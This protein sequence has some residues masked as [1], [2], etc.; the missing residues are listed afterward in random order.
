[1]LVPLSVARLEG[2]PQLA[3]KDT[4]YYIPRSRFAEYQQKVRER[5]QRNGLTVDVNLIQDQDQQSRLDNW[6]ECQDYN[7]Q[8]LAQFEKDVEEVQ[9]KLESAQKELRDAGAVELEGE[10]ESNMYGLYLE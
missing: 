7:Y 2:I 9:E 5:L 4:Q 3:A 8:K 6:I 10:F 1:L